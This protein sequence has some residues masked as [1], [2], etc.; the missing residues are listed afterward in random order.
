MR[1]PASAADAPAW[2]LEA[3][4]E[5]LGGGWRATVRV[6]GG[7]RFTMYV[8]AHLANGPSIEALLNAI[9]AEWPSRP[10]RVIDEV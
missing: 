4:V 3:L 7:Q 9:V 2:T 5:V 8:A 10:S 6:R 1:Q